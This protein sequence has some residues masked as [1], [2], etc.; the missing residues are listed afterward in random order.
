M[1]MYTYISGSFGYGDDPRTV[2]GVR[3][4][5]LPDIL[6]ADSGK[7]NNIMKRI[8][9]LLLCLCTAICLSSCG[10]SKKS[11]DDAALAEKLTGTW[12][13]FEDE[14]LYFATFSNTE[15]G[16]AMSYG[17]PNSDFRQGGPLTDAN[18]LSENVWEFNVG[19]VSGTTVVLKATCDVTDIDTG[20]I[21]LTN[22][23]YNNNVC[24][25][26]KF[27]DTSDIKSWDG[28]DD[29]EIAK[30]VKYLVTF[31]SDGGGFFDPLKLKKGEPFPELPLAVKDGRKFEYWAYENGD[32]AEAGDI[33]PGH[34]VSLFAVYKEQFTVT[35]DTRGGDPLPPIVL[36]V[37]DPLPE[38][39]TPEREDC[40]FSRWCDAD[41]N[42]IN[43]GD[44]LPG[45]DTTIYA[46]YFGAVTITFD[47]NGGSACE[48]MKTFANRAL[49]KLPTPKRD[50]YQFIAWK[51]KNGVPISEGA[52]LEEGKIT[53]YAEWSK[54]GKINFDSN[55]G[56]S[57]SPL[58]F[59]EDYPLPDLPT[60]TRD[61]YEFQG[62]Y[63][64][65][66]MYFTGGS[67]ISAEEFTLHARWRRYGTIT[68][69]SRG[70]TACAPMKYYEDEQIYGLPTPTKEGY[71]F[72]H[73]E[74]KWGHAILDGAL[75][76]ADN[77]VLYAVWIEP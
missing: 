50:G 24:R 68:F 49:P 65:H 45:E 20:Y 8:L 46:W 57:C 43:S 9:A 32:P 58:Y 36:N 39:P 37:G 34:P 26:Q 67:Y 25:F 22:L 74:N 31:S 2:T 27:L 4:E 70:G 21:D 38:L 7:V 54:Q 19:P 13:C 56:S 69:D 51:D 75:L 71:T 73:W 61:G 14:F 44:V 52:L 66:E 15:E 17:I 10:K 5:T 12:V 62:W 11:A 48:Q 64:D 29:L 6:T 23:A 55:G 16:P 53:L 30:D 3:Y 76:T 77:I 72:G 41:K 42:T 28:L 63:D 60:P 1:M 59:A 18:E 35:L 47:S 40:L 33:M